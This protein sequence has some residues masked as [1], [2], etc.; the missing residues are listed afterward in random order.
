MYFFSQ[1]KKLCNEGLKEYENSVKEYFL[2][3]R[4]DN[5]FLLLLSHY[6]EVV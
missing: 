4:K 2:F 3:Y 6:L 5:G 1:S